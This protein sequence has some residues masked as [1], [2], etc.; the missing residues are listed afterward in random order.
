M[1]V[2]RFLKDNSPYTAGEVASFGDQDA[3]VRISAG[4]AELVKH[5]ERQPDQRVKTEVGEDGA[6]RIETRTVPDDIN[7]NVDLPPT[8][9]GGKAKDEAHMSDEEKR[10]VQA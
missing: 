9:A 3:D 6:T 4:V 8:R 7:R 10:R 2:V 1:K 5:Y